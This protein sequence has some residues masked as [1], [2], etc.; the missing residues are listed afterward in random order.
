MFFTTWYSDYIVLIIHYMNFFLKGF[1]R[2]LFCSI[3]RIGMRDN[4]YLSQLVKFVPCAVASLFEVCGV[5]TR[6]VFNGFLSMFE[7]VNA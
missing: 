6:V 7:F 2:S 5:G 1:I 4:Y 3:V